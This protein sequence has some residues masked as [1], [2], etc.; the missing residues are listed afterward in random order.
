MGKAGCA[1]RERVMAEAWHDDAMAARVRDAAKEVRD[2]LAAMRSN[3]RQKDTL[4]MAR[5]I[6]N[7]YRAA[8]K[9]GTE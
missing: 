1:Q 6:I 9:G 5:R 3:V 8:P 7:E 4:A 2:S